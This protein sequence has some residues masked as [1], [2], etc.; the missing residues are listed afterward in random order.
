M[1]IEV[2]VV[3]IVVDYEVFFLDSK[4]SSARYSLQWCLQIARLSRGRVGIESAIK[5]RV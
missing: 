5:L 3:F 4:A 2:K 1:E